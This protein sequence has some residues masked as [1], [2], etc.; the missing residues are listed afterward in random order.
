MGCFGQIYYSGIEVWQ[1]A[2]LLA[3]V[4]FVSV[5]LMRENMSGLREN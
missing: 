5:S 1:I 4:S 3:M 2:Q